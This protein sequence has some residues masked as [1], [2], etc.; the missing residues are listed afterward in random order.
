MPG[1]C[2]YGRPNCVSPVRRAV[3]GS[4]V[5]STFGM[6]PSIRMRVTSSRVS[7]VLIVP[8]MSVDPR[9]GI[10]IGAFLSFASANRSS[11]ACR[12]P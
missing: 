2:A 10:E 4:S 9:L 11:L 12:H 1:S 8:P 3:R 7:S 5:T 6:K